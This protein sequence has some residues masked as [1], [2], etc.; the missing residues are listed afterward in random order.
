MQLNK[1]KIGYRL[2]LGFGLMLMMMAGI[3]A[4]A[5][6]SS[7]QT[8]ANLNQTVNRT[9]AKSVHVAAMRQSLFR[10]GLLARNIGLLTDP[11][12]MQTE[13]GKIV[14]EQKAY[15]T[16]SAKLTEAGLS[17]EEQ[18]IIAEMKQHEQNIVPLMKQAQEYVAA[19]NARQAMQVLT[20]Q[21]TP[22]QDKWLAAIDRMVDLQTRQIEGNLAEFES[23]SN[24]ANLLM[25]AISAVSMLLAAGVGWLLTRSIVTPLQEAV[26]VARRVAS[27]DLGMHVDVHGSDETGQLLAA[28]S[29]MNA[30]LTGIVGGVREGTDA[31]GVASREIASGNADLSARTEAQAGSLQETA[32]S[33]S[34]L[35]TIVKQNAENA[36][37]ANRLV[38][39]ASELA[40]KGGD[41]VGQVVQTM[42]SIKDSSRRIVD[43]IGVI[44]GIAFQTNIL[45][46][47]AAVEAARAG[48]QGRGFAVVAAEV[49]NLAQRSASAAKE[50]KALIDDSVTR[51]DGGSRLVDDAGHTMEQVV[52]AVKRVAGIMGEIASSSYEQSKGIAEVNQAV[53]RMDDMTQQNAA[54]VEEAA[55]AAQSMQE[56]AERL[57]QAVSVFHLSGASANTTG[58]TGAFGVTRA[59]RV[60]GPASAPALMYG[61]R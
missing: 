59:T 41:V 57:V 58:A 11:A 61:G 26:G 6:L 10:Q 1:I 56:Q 31:I 47:N 44:D 16:A 55:A 60:A 32:A 43:I 3:T 42:G 54:L 30:S 50:I 38:I 29:D 53:T 17:S 22:I 19:F 35:T 49:R 20:T 28:L 2:A 7:K 51:V 40:L 52:E 36:E 33:M 39:E 5:V 18:S 8:R 14:T 21:A 27:G 24:R 46:L 45:A 9:K 4:I 13:I 37:Q 34:H 15:D 12:A 23:E 48:E 25:I